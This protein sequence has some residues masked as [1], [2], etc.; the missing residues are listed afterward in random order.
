MIFCGDCGTENPEAKNFC[1]KCGHALYSSGSASPVRFITDSKHGHLLIERVSDTATLKS[2]RGES[3]VALWVDGSLVSTS[4][5]PRTGQR[6]NSDTTANA[7]GSETCDENPHALSAKAHETLI[8]YGRQIAA[9]AKSHDALEHRLA[10]WIEKTS[11]KVHSEDE[12]AELKSLSDR[13][14]ALY[15]EARDLKRPYPARDIH[16]EWIEMFRKS[17]EAYFIYVM[18]QREKDPARIQSLHGRLMDAEQEAKRLSLR[19]KEDLLFL[20]ERNGIHLAEYEN[21]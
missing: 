7:F 2:R 18:S 5:R 12:R 3:A 14:L 10:A 16:D 4:P 6:R 15:I 8:A 20:L 13:M 19:A 17:Y 9:L 11:G 1:W 21:E